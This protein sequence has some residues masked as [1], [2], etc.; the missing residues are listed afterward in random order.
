MNAIHL[1]HQHLEGRDKLHHVMDFNLHK[2]PIGWIAIPE[3]R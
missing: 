3:N 1:K 2:K